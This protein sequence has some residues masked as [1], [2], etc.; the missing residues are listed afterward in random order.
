MRNKKGFTMTELLAVIVILSVIILIAVTAILPRMENARKNTFIDEALAYLKAGKEIQVSGDNSAVCY[1]ISNFDEYVKQDKEGYSGTLFVNSNRV[2]LNLTN[3]TYYIKADTKRN[4]TTADLQETKPNDFIESCTDTSKTYT[5]TYNLDGGT[6]SSENPASYN[7]NTPAFT[8]NNPT[9][10]GYKFVGWSGGKNLFNE[11][12]LLMAISGATKVDGYYKFKVGSMYSLYGNSGNTFPIT[13][14]KSSTRYI[15]SFNGHMQSSYIKMFF[16]YDG[17]S[18]S[19]QFK[20]T[21]DGPW[22]V[23][24]SSGKTVIGTKMSYGSNKYAYIRYIQL[25]EGTKATEYEPYVDKKNELIIPRG[26][27]GNRTYTAM[28]E[29]I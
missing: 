24:S 23:T 21:K 29:A 13:N 8:L 18:S 11:E 28:W 6:L 20:L 4:L 3:G 10:S 16:L 12:E 9:K 15:Y 25:E 27:S 19:A 26:S 14:F 17:T 22:T 1:D 5:I 2:S 7:I